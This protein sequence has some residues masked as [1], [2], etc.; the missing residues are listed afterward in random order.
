MIFIKN[1]YTSI[2]YNIID[3][4]NTRKL[5]SE[6]YKEK[7]HII[8]KSL[9]G[10]DN[11]ENLVFLTGREHLICHLLLI[12]MTTGKNKASMISAAW[13]MANLE[14]ANQERK[15]LNS[16]QY[17]VLREE[18]SKTHSKRMRENNPMHDPDVRKK[19]DLSIIKRGKTSGMTG[20]KHSIESNIKRK[21]ANK[22][23]FVPIEKRLAASKFHSNRS[24][25]LK[26]MYDQI[27]A[28]N[29][30]C[31]FC[32]KMANPGTF[33]RWHGDNCKNKTK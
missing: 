21:L 11:I 5:S 8:P 17:A 32:Q 30:C 7:H 4:A 18:F 2:Y 14:N 33:K 12:K 6:I 16:R 19:Y 27:H 31:T 15:K 10:G 25:E 29:I 3:R 22:G 9:G 1:K 23:Q 26:S 20:K 28:S 13:S 24:P